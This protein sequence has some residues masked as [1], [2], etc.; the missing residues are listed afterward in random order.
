MD[1]KDRF[2]QALAKEMRV[3]RHHFNPATKH[4]WPL[5]VGHIVER[6]VIETLG[7]CPDL[8]IWGALQRQG[9]TIA[10]DKEDRM[11]IAVKGDVKKA[12]VK[13]KV[14]KARWDKKRKKSQAKFTKKS[15]NY[16]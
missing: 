3:V 10:Y 16:K 8:F 5:D 13:R 12:M 11:F 15:R 2:K 1:T 4:G 7:F 6:V 14:E 9:L